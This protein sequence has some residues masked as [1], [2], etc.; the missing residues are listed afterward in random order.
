MIIVRCARPIHPPYPHF[1][2]RLQPE[3]EPPPINERDSDLH[4]KP[5]TKITVFMSILLI[6]GMTASLCGGFA[7]GILVDRSLLYHPAAIALQPTQPPTRTLPPSSTPLPTIT[8]LPS[9]TPVP[10]ETPTAEAVLPPSGGLDMKLILEARRMIE[11]HYVDRQAIDDK[12]LTYGAI[13]G[14]VAALGDTGHSTF[15]SAEAYK[16]YSGSLNGQYEGIGAYIEARGGQIVIVAPIDGSPAQKQGLHPGDVILKVDGK[17][18]SG[19]TVA[20]ARNLILGPAG[21]TVT[22]IIYSPS[23][24]L[25]REVTLTRAKIIIKNVTW[26]ALPGTTIAHLRLSQF[27]QGATQDLIKAIAEIKQQNMT[28]II[29]DLRNNPGGLVSE[30]VGVASQFLP[31]GVIFKEKDAAGKVINIPVKEGGTATQIPLVV[32]VN[33]GSASASEIV[34]GAI[35][36]AQRGKLVGET[37]F[38]TGTVLTEFPLSDGSALI[39]AIKE[40]LTPKDR[41]IWHIGIVPDEVVKLELNVAPLTPESERAFSADDLAKSG[42]QQILKAI[43]LLKK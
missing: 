28:A 1:F 17:D 32:L 12:E 25:E 34:S 4:M 33:H 31:N 24:N 8:P 42:D 27:S 43:D 9:D 23:T 5:T 35:Q 41:V 15:L 36:D 7:G 3:A 30:A 2:E 26:Q 6:L 18:I 11:T 37:T 40:W 21:T 20:E 19:M 13:S 16:A 14:M 10:F 39:L 22:L 38:G 29:F